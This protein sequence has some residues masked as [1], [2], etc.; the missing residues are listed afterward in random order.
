MPSGPQNLTEQYQAAK[1][2]R[3]LADV[4]RKPDDAW[5]EKLK[6]N[7]PEL[8][9]RLVQRLTEKENSFEQ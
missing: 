6:Q 3:E 4:D 5:L 7:H 1:S 9:Q 8:F 2:K